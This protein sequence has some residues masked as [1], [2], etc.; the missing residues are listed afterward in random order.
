ML[1]DLAEAGD[2]REPRLV[3]ALADLALKFAGRADPGD[4]PTL[5]D[6]LPIL[7]PGAGVDV[8]QAPDPQRP[9][10]RPFA[11]CDE[12]EILTDAHLA[13][14]VDPVVALAR[15]FAGPGGFGFHIFHRHKMSM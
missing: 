13:G 8:K 7:A 2:R 10:G 4:A 12:G 9:I 6:D 3:D 15:W 5:D 1:V 11:Q 14:G